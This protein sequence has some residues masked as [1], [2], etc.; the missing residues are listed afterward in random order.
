MNS[1]LKSIKGKNLETLAKHK[2]N[3]PDWYVDTGNYP[4]NLQVS[5]KVF[6]GY[7]GRALW[8]LAG[9][10]ATGKTRVW[11]Q[12]MK[13]FLSED[14]NRV[15][16]VISTENERDID[17]KLMELYGDRIL[18]IAENDI[19]TVETQM[20]NL[21]ARMKTQNPNEND[22]RSMIVLDSWGFLEYAG[23]IEKAEAGKQ[24]IMDLTK[25]R[26]QS[27]LATKL[28]YQP[29]YTNSIL[30]ITNHVYIPPDM[31]ASAI[32]SGGKKLA[33]ASQ[34]ITVLS[35]R[36]ADKAERDQKTLIKIENR[37]ARNP[38]KEGT[39]IV[40]PMEYHKGGLTRYGGL[41]ELCYEQLGAIV[42]PS[43]GWYAWADDPNTKFRKKQVEEEPE[44]YFTVE[45]LLFIEKLAQNT[46]C[47][48]D[49]PVRVNQ[50]SE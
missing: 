17:D 50:L 15:G 35:K 39:T 5:G 9:E 14:E 36:K 46:F 30:F 47:Y 43:S 42:S 3:Y 29:L 7:K 34:G 21:F 8:Q 31:Y 6:G 45:R 26:L 44:V 18:L 32:I 38:V 19:H 33:Y 49:T 4:L 28:I 11:V 25:V 23:A 40:V 27:G 41:F 20:L 24:G 2:D 12:C 48:T 16:I 13:N 1:F 22:I 37:K 10:E